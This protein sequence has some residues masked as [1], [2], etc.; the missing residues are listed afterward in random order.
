MTGRLQKLCQACSPGRHLQECPGAQAGKCPKE[1][2]LSDFRHLAR[3]TPSPDLPALAFLERARG[4]PQK[5]KGFS[6]CGTPKNLGKGRK[7]APKSKENRKTKKA[8]NRKKQGLEGQGGGF[9]FFFSRHF[10][11]PQTS[12]RTQKNSLGHS[13][14][15]QAL[16]TLEKEAFRR[17][18]P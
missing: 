18:H 14:P 3:S 5:S 8:R 10:L 12:K 17:G 11:S 7:N 9:F 15:G 1:C 2:F 13:E 16:E 6:L 4:F